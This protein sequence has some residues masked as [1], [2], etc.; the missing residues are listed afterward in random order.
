MSKKEPETYYYDATTGERVTATY[1]VTLSVPSDYFG[2][3]DVQAKSQ[4]E[5]VRLALGRAEYADWEHPKLT[6]YGVDIEVEFVECYD[7]PKGALLYE[8]SS[9]EADITECF[10]ESTFSELPGTATDTRFQTD[11]GKESGDE[12]K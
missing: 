12:C 4:E 5:A 6:L 10:E 11:G 2:R 9:S 7:P 3:I 8:P 1:T